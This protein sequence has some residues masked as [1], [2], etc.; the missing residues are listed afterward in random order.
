MIT[1]EFKVT[2]IN[3]MLMI[4]TMAG[5]ASLVAAGAQA[6]AQRI[7]VG[8]LSQAQGAHAFEAQV[9]AAARNLCSGYSQADLARRDACVAAVREEAVAQLSSTQRA[10]LAT[11]NHGM[12]MAAMAGH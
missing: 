9:A 6:Q 5:C 2:N 4:A 10:E 7:H 3:R 12:A 11:P 8:D 1:G